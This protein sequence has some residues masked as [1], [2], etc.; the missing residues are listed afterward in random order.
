MT[1]QPIG[2]HSAALYLTPAD[3]REHGATPEGITRELALL[4]TR[5]AFAKAGLSVEGEVEIEAYP[6]ACGVLVFARFQPP[7]QVWFPFPSLEEVLTAARDLAHLCPQG[8]LVWCENT[9]WLSVPFGAEQ[10]ICRLS[11]FTRPASDSPFRD[12]R[13][14][15]H[16]RT[17][18]SGCALG[19][20]LEYFP[21]KLE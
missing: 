13:L 10:A 11:E 16:G 18:L 12:A 6:E 8:D 7:K 2:A 17:L 4:L 5:E 20:L 3:L 19:A 21:E 14:S 9:Y 1:I 15:E